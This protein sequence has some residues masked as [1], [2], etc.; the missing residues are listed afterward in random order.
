MQRGGRLIVPRFS[1]D[2]GP[3]AGGLAASEPARPLRGPGP[4]AGERARLSWAALLKRVFAVDVPHC[5]RCGGPRRI[6]AVQAGPNPS[7][8]CSRGWGGHPLGAH[9]ASHDDQHRER[10]TEN[11]RQIFM[12]S[13]VLR[14]TEKEKSTRPRCHISSR[15]PTGWTAISARVE[16][17]DEC[18][19]LAVRECHRVKS[20]TI[21]VSNVMY[22]NTISGRHHHCCSQRNRREAPS[23]KGRATVR[24]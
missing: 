2:A 21:F 16:A 4:S 20:Q 3:E 10:R 9:G 15:A 5:P 7:A 12:M 22:S 24:W 13:E 6:V 18:Q 17:R 8:R 11:F 19:L 14:S 23:D 1:E